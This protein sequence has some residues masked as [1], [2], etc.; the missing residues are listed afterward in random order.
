MAKG[1][2][3][4]TLVT[5]DDVMQG[6]IAAEDISKL[7]FEQ[8]LG[9]LE[10]VVTGVESG[11]LPLDQAIGSYERGTELVQHLRGLLAG[12]EEK[13]RMLSDEQ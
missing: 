3:N 8:A 7:S 11:S 13:L 12:A 4:D 5:V 6:R 10:G 1:K 9:L 2:N